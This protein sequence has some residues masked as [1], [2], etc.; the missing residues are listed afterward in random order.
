MKKIAILFSFFLLLIATACSNNEPTPQERF[1]KYINHWNNQEFTEMYKMIS[2]NSEETYPTEDFVDRYENIYSDLNISSLQVSFENLSEEQMETA[3]DEGTAQFPFTVEMESIAGPISFDYEATLIREESGEDDSDENWFVKW[4]PGFIFPEIKDGAD[5]RLETT[6]PKRGEILDRNRMPLALNDTVNE[7]GIV[8]EKL[9]DDPKQA[10]QEIADLL[11]ISVETIDSSLNQDWVK[12]N[13][14]VPLKKLPPSAENTVSQLLEVD[15]V[16]IREATGRVYPLGEAASHLTGYISQVTAEDLEE[17][18]SDKYDSEDMIGQRGLESLF[19]ERLKGEEG[20]KI[21][22]VRENGEETVIAEKEAENGENIVTTIDAEVQETIYESYGDD[23]GTAAAINPKT[24]ETLA[25]V[26]SPGFAPNKFL[27]GISQSEYDELQNDPKKPT[28]NRFSATFAPGSA[29][30]PVTAAI[31]LN[32]G[33]IVPGEGME[34]NGLTWSNG[35]GWGDYEVRRVSESNGP[36]DITNA[37]VRSDNIYFARKAVEMGSDKFVNGLQQFGFGEDLPFDYPI[38]ASTISS[39]GSINDEVLLANTSYGQGEIETSSLHLALTYT[40]LLNDGNM[41]KP[42]LLADTEKG[43]VWKEGLISSDHA[44]LI[45]EALRD[46]VAANNGTAK[47]A[48]DAD[49]PISGKTGTAEL[50]LTDEEEN[51]KENGW[52]VGYPSEDQ[53]ILIAMMVEN[54]QDKGGSGYTVE[55][56]TDILKEVK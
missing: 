50:K 39:S 13:M 1:E 6:E 28:L 15:G 49:F 45:Q 34:I 9:G 8:P 4:N 30:K 20:A 46:V 48:Q 11:G 10:K 38:T 36:V 21:S 33:S 24:G 29:I 42:T 52:F 53:D 3:M 25:L 5:I 26:S 54:T 14:H 55:K 35:E 31:G 37:L 16:S 47:Q 17:L 27:Y 44:T 7:V 12:P 51:G 41:L 56:V 18:D 23:T 40:P 19:E 32:N 22:A 2:S 43:Q